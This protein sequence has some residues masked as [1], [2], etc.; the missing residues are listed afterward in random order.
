MKPRRKKD[1]KAIEA[2]RKRHCELCGRS[3]ARLEVHHVI[4]RGAGGPDDPCNL[5]C[6]C[7]FCHRE[8]HDGNIARDKLWRVI[9]RRE[10]ST[11]EEVQET[12][13]LYRQLA[14]RGNGVG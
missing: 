7:A 9:A 13:M 10:R 5:V 6:L 12:A 14:H 11:P 4:T 1:K 2:I 8:V 3:D